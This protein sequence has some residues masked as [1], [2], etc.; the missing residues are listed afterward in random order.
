MAR[1]LLALGRGVPR[2]E[3]DVHD[4][5]GRTVGRTT[6]GTFSPTLRQGI[7]VALLDPAIG[8]GDE[9]SVSVRGRDLSCRVVRPPF[10]PIETRE[11]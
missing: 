5:N 6:S 11:E 9:V 10:V 1:G 7:A 3:M 4:L 8:E 2:P